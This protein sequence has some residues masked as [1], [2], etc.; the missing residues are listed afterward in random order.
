VKTVFVERRDE[1]RVCYINRIFDSA[2]QQHVNSKTK[3]N[4]YYE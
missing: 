3:R 2:L 1:G 4:N